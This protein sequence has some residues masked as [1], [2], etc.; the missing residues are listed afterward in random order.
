MERGVRGDHWIAP[1]QLRQG[2]IPCHRVEQ[3]RGRCSSRSVPSFAVDRSNTAWRLHR[4]EGSRLGD[5]RYGADGR[6][7]IGA[8]DVDAQLGRS[9]ERPGVSHLVQAV[10]RVLD[11]GGVRRVDH[12]DDVHPHRAARRD[13]IR[14][15][16]LDRLRAG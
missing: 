8:E 15:G 1:R 7:P 5:A 2:D 11:V 16:G 9:P 3:D 14:C 10:G 4:H 6:L 12:V 13:H